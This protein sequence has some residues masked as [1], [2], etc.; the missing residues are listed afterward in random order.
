MIL[1]Q[2]DLFC[3]I[4]EVATFSCGHTVVIVEPK[5]IFPDQTVQ[6]IVNF[7]TEEEF[8]KW[9]KG[10]ESTPSTPESESAKGK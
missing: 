5:T 10:M 9:I 1:K 7:E 2:G 3:E 4:G 8:Q 6:T